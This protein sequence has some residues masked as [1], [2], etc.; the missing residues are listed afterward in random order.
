[1]A[2]KMFVAP[3]R[4]TELWLLWDGDRWV[5]S[6]DEAPGGFTALASFSREEALAAAEHQKQVYDV[7]CIPVRVMGG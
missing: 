1:M 6:W 2:E 5:P 4:P 3:Q 7:D